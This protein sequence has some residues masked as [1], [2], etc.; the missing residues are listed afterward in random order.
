[1][2]GVPALPPRRRWSKVCRRAPS[3]D[4]EFHREHLG[5]LL[6]GVRGDYSALPSCSA[7]QLITS[8]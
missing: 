3:P 8:L 4:D 2:G 5:S 1:M 7:T 6:G